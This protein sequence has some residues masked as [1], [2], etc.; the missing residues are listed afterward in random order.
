[1]VV[2]ESHSLHVFWK[3]QRFFLRSDQ[4]KYSSDI[5]QNNFRLKLWNKRQSAICISSSSVNPIFRSCSHFT[6][7]ILFRLSA[8]DWGSCEFGE[9]ILQMFIQIEIYILADA[10]FFHFGLCGRWFLLLESPRLYHYSCVVKVNKVLLSGL[11]MKMCCLSAELFTGWRYK[12]GLKLRKKTDKQKKDKNLGISF[13]SAA[14]KKK[15]KNPPD[16]IF[17]WC[18]FVLPEQGDFC[19]ATD[20]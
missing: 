15:K 13:Y 17:W 1:M 8:T 2:T 5:S 11:G 20:K 4:N 10:L 6:I 16:F 7:Y 12:K 3:Q 9:F 14:F 19:L 18:I